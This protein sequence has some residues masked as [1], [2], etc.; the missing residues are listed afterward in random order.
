[1][2]FDIDKVFKTRKI[3]MKYEGTAIDGI[4]LEDGYHDLVYY[5]I[6]NS[7]KP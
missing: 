1:M 3:G 7:Q 2:N 6:I 4:M 5:A